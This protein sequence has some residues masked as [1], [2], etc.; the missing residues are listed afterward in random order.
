MRLIL[1]IGLAAALLAGGVAALQE[2]AYRAHAYVIRVPP[3]YAGEGGLRQARSTQVLERALVLAHAERSTAWLRERSRVQHTGR[4]DFA[5]TVRAPSAGEASALATGYA[6]AVK[7]SLRKVPG[8]ATRGRGARTAERSLGP[9]GWA[10]IGGAV[11]LWLGAAVTI[12][13]SGSRRGPRRA[14]APG[15]PATRPTPG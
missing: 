2:R 14:S 9:V 5:I 3:A 13:R 12:V 7:L 6:K 1:G 10:V 11:G 15:A 8:L 4:G